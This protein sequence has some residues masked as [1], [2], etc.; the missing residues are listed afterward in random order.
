MKTSYLLAFSL[1]AGACSQIGFAGE[2]TDSYTTGDTLTATSLN[3]IKSAVNDNDAK[4]RKI[5]F[6]TDSV[7]QFLGDITLTSTT[8]ELVGLDFICPLDGHVVAT[9]STQVSFSL[10]PGIFFAPRFQIWTDVIE[11]DSLLPGFAMVSVVG[12]PGAVPSLA[13]NSNVSTV[14][15]FP[16][17]AGLLVRYSVNGYDPLNGQNVTA[18][19]TNLVLQFSADL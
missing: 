4:I 18:N 10:N 17:A 1:A 2:I 16:C 3:N 19:Q 9:M 11:P 12:Q 13:F 6:K 7:Y 8:Q 5:A 15:R 14:A